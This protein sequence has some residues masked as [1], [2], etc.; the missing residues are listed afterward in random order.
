MR[1]FGD[2][3]SF[4]GDKV[5]IVGIKEEASLLDERFG[6]GCLSVSRGGSTGATCLE[7]GR[8][9]EGLMDGVGVV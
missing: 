8:A 4:V 3:V 2:E 7:S 1:P 5:A 9:V 6:R